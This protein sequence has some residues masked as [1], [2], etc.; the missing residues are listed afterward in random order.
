[1]AKTND[2]AYLVST[3]LHEQVTEVALLRN[4]LSRSDSDAFGK[5][6][7]ELDQLRERLQKVA[8]DLENRE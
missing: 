6:I 4:E 1:M 2:T 3:R 5:E 7:D 8:N